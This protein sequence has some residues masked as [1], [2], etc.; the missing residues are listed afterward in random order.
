MNNRNLILVRGISGCGKT[1]FAELMSEK[2][3]HPVDYPVLSADDYF[4]D[5]DGNYNWSGP[6]LPKAHA[7]CLDQTEQSM[8]EGEE[9]IFVANTLAPERE[10]VPY[11]DMA[12]RYG[13]R[14]FSIVV[15]NRHEGENVHNVPEASIQ[16]QKNRFKVKL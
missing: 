15:E 11:Y 5:K 7:W 13:Y 12:K 2:Y 14:V 4:F 9:K 16:K 10:L 1:T 6:E 8:I 3:D